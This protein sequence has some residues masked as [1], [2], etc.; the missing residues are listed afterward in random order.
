MTPEDRLLR[1]YAADDSQSAFDEL[2]RRH[3]GFVL[4]VCGRKLQDPELAEDAAQAVFILLARKAP[5][6][7]PGTVLSGWLFQTAILVCRNTHRAEMRRKRYEQRAMREMD[8]ATGETDGIWNA[9]EPHLDDALARLSGP[10][11][12]AVLLRYVEEMTLHEVGAALGITAAA[13]HKRISRALDRL[14]AAS[15]EA[16]LLLYGRGHGET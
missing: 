3:Y 9:I 5:S 14:R 11:R 16:R 15:A 2:V 12:D 7:R 6:F 13:A 10:E 1:R 8:V 4:A